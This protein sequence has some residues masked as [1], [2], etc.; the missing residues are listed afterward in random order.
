[1]GLLVFQAVTILRLL[2]PFLPLLSGCALLANQ[3]SL[4]PNMIQAAQVAD[5]TKT[6]ADM[7]SYI[8]TGR[9]L[10]DNTISRALGK[11]CKLTRVMDGAYCVADD[12]L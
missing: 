2:L 11:D 1:M 7:A 9:S 12:P 4:A 10:L 3:L 8:N 6:S 5:W